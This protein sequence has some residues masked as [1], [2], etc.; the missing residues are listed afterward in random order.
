MF[1][2]E[3][4][5]DV[6]YAHISLPDGDGFR[7]FPV[8]IHKF[9]DGDSLSEPL[10]LLTYISD[11]ILTRDYK[12]QSLEVV[13][14]L[15]VDVPMAKEKNLNKGKRLKTWFSTEYPRGNIQNCF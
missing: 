13:I 15:R 12:L 7:K 1:Y 5:D 14:V 6:L 3:V 8:R 11:S 10:N 9:G 2:L 4:V